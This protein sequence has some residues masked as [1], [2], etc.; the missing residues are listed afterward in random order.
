MA[1]CGDSW[2]FILWVWYFFA[3]VCVGYQEWLEIFSFKNASVEAHFS[4]T[5]TEKKGVV[6]FGVFA[7]RPQ[8]V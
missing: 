3:F 5:R 1:V 8:P 7:R 6:A 4:T 2:C